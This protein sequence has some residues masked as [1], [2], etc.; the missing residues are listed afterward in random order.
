MSYWASLTADE[1]LSLKT[2][3]TRMSFRDGSVVISQHDTSGVVVIL[4]SGFVKAVQRIRPGRHVVL[5]IRGPGDI[6]GEMATI[7]AGR[8]SVAVVAIGDVAG[9][10]ISQAVF[11]A[12]LEGSAHAS[13]ALHR[14]IV[15]RLREADRERLAAATMTVRQRLAYLLLSLANRYGQPT[16]DGVVL[17]LFSQRDFAAC[18]GG[19]HRSVA[20]EISSWR[21]A[22]VV[23][24]G[25]RQITVHQPDELRRAL[26]MRA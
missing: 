2:A 20:R 24:V 14:T 19:A 12:F 18:I 21:R 3:G 13:R 15:A 4:L 16:T 6:L 8:R 11:H 25:R 1:R 22:H 7:D 9:L 5:A 26:S 23:S 10:V 17:R